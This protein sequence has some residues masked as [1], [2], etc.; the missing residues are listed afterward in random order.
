MSARSLQECKDVLREIDKDTLDRRAE[1]CRELGVTITSAQEFYSQRERDYAREASW[2]YINGNYRSAILCCACSVDQVFR[3]EYLKVSRNKYEDLW[4]RRR[5]LTFGEVIGKCEDQ[6][7]L[8]LTPF[9]EKAKLL[10]RIRNEVAV[11]PLFTDVPCTSDTERQLRDE[12]IRRDVTALL[13]LIGEIDKE[14]KRDIEDTEL[15]NDVEGWRYTFREAM[16][17]ESGLPTSS[18][19][20]F[21]ALIEENVLRFLAKHASDIKREILKDLYPA[22]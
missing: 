9:M 3:Y 22:E 14:R 4:R 8:R 7:V 5:Q 6:K 11:H 19:L 17:Q 12:W 20:G 18:L 2:S 10:N 16:G 15:I 1:R 13:N 21:W